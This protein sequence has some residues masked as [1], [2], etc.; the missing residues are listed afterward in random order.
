MSVYERDA[1]VNEQHDLPQ[2]INLEGV[3]CAVLITLHFIPNE[4]IA[5]LS[6]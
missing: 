4:D 2:H 6:K 5:G 1:S 3:C